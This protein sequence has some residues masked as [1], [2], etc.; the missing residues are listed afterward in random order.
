V[1]LRRKLATLLA[2]ALCIAP[3]A[4]PAAAAPAL[5]STDVSFTDGGTTLH[6]TVLAPSGGTRHAAMVLMGG[7][8]WTTRAKLAAEATA[9][10]D[11]GLVVLTYDK[12]TVGYSTTHRDYDALARDA[13]AAVAV[14]R[15]RPDV[16]PNRVG[17]FGVSEGGYVAPRAAVMSDSIAFVVTGGA[18]GMNGAQQSAWYW[19]NLLR[20]EGV[21]GSLLRTFPLTGTRMIVG[22]GLFPEADYDPVTVLRRVRQPLLAIWGEDDPNHPAQESSA[23]FAKAL[24]EGG[25]GDYAIRFVPN[26]GPDLHLTRDGGWDRLPQLAPGY[27]E[28]VTAWVAKL[29]SGGSGVSVQQ[30]APR[31][32]RQTV[33][34]APLAWYESIPVQLG[35]LLLFALCFLGYLTAGLFRRGQPVVAPRA[36]RVL[37]WCGLVS[38]LGFVGWFGFLSA[39]GAQRLGPVLFGRPLPWLVLQLLALATVIGVIVVAIAWWRRRTD[40][41]QRWRLGALL[42]AGVVFVP[43]SLYWGLL[44]P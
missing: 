30:P 23:I 19:E 40:A 28:L 10:A 31:Q 29:A 42:V 27:P 7:S 17:L 34:L 26:A 16:D 38:V 24:A 21:R 32:D 36:A 41:R 9:F 20:H 33:P 35:A 8:D 37:A 6:G 44:L 15:A 12:R 18:L 22:A 11:G 43:W 13:L 14:L 25:N 2:L 1:L 5:I 3:L 39:T 4:T